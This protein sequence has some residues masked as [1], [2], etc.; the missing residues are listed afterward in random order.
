[1][2]AGNTL[3]KLAFVKIARVRVAEFATPVTA[4]V[5][6]GALYDVALLEVATGR[7]DRGGDFFERVVAGRAAGF[8]EL[9]ARLL[10]GRRATEA[11]IVEGEF[12]PL[13]PCDGARGAYV[14]LGP[15]DLDTEE[16]AF[17]SRD[18][19]AFVGDAQP[20]VIRAQSVVASVGLAVMLAED[21]EAAGPLE[22]LRAVLGWTLIIEWS[23]G[24]AAKTGR[25]RPASTLGPW[26]VLQP[27]LAGVLGKSLA[28]RHRGE[29]R[30][31]D[32]VDAR[33]FTVGESLAFLSHHVALRAG[34]V[35]GLGC[36]RGGRVQLAAGERIHVEL[37]G[38][39]SLEGWTSELPVATAWRAS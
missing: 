26:L 23:H 31:T 29:L 2:H 39:M 37:P 32:A 11:R 15:S 21:L 10:A 7:P 30:M 12:L 1:M 13:A 34:D 28:L 24:D 36:A 20:V 4:L 8:G 3:S 14:Q 38:V 25:P 22:A 35:V 17:E 9:H 33:A 16:P 18:S 6:D 27:N 5:C 19:R